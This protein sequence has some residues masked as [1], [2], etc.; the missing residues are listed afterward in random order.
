MNIG[1]I[2]FYYSLPSTIFRIVDYFS[3]FNFILKNLLF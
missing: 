3:H 2:D 1:T